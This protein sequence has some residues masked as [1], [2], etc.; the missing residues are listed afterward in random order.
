M[1]N[2]ANIEQPCNASPLQFTL[3]RAH[4]I[5]F[6][7]TIPYCMHVVMHLGQTNAFLISQIETYETHR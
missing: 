1:Q 3:I 5:L 7:R 6:Y 2:L 4:K